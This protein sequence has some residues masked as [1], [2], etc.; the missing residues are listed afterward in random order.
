MEMLQRKGFPKAYHAGFSNE[1][2]EQVQHDFQ[3]DNIQIIVATIAFG[4]G[5]I[6]RI[7]VLCCIMIYREVLRPIIRKPVG[8]GVMIRRC[9]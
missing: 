6:N 9:G 3:R 8:Q 5:L 4:M 2:R 7:S 1:I